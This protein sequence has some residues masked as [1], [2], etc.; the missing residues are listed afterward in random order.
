MR[1]ARGFV[2]SRT[3]TS[4]LG[5][6]KGAVKDLRVSVELLTTASIDDSGGRRKSS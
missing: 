3:G 5:N 1:L 2:R 6:D 4:P